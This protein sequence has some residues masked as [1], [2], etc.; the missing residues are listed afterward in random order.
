MSELCHLFRSCSIKT[1]CMPIQDSIY[2]QQNLENRPLKPVTPENRSRSFIHEFKHSLRY[3][4]DRGGCQLRPNNR[5]MQ[6]IRLANYYNFIVT[7]LS[8]VEG[9]H[10]PLPPPTAT[11]KEKETSIYYK[12]RKL[13]QVE[14]QYCKQKQKLLI[15]DAPPPP[16]WGVL[17]FECQYI[18]SA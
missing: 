18:G 12:K 2:C 10:G 3:R 1:L 6:G 11:G 16:P 9:E 13:L 17:P 7:K 8:S 15:A 5:S 14:K 4:R